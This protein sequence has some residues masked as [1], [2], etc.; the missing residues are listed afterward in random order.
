M[1]YQLCIRQHPVAGILL[2]ILCLVGYVVLFTGIAWM[3]Y[4]SFAFTLEKTLWTP[5]LFLGL[6]STAAWVLLAD[7]PRPLLP[8]IALLLQDLGQIVLGFSVA[9]AFFTMFFAATSDL[10]L[11]ESFYL[12]VPLTA[13]SAMVRNYFCG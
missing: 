5:C 9:I 8:V 11:I 1:L 13:A 3:T 6:A 12:S 7:G 2:W 10:G 4:G